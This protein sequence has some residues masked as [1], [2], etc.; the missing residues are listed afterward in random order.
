VV[1][2]EIGDERLESHPWP[3]ADEPTDALLHIELEQAQN[4]IEYL[5]EA[6]RTSRE[7]GVAIGILMAREFCTQEQAFDW[8]REASQRTHRKLREIAHD[9]RRTGTLPDQGWSTRE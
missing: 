9:V 4:K 3:F 1:T 6:L 7:I 8:L 5:Q 2:S